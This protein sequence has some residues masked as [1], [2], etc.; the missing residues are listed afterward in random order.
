MGITAKITAEITADWQAAQ[1]ALAWQLDMGVD[2]AMGDAPQSA[3]DLP[4]KAEWQRPAAQLAA[5]APV[6][7]NLAASKP[8]SS[9]NLPPSAGLD[10]AQSAA[11]CKNLEELHAAI[12]QFDHL[13]L[14]KGARN[15]VFGAGNPRADILILGDAPSREDERD[16]IPFS[17][18]AGQ[19]LDRMFAAIGYS[20]HDPNPS[21][22]LY[23]TCALPW[24][25]PQD[26]S[27]NADEIDI[28]RPFVQRHID[29]VAPSVIVLMG[30]AALQMAQQATGIARARGTWGTAFGVDVMPMFP[31]AYVLANPAAKRDAWADLLAIKARLR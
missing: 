28:F 23:L 14:K 2:E 7:Q 13:E 11:A 6:V 25:T 1:A 20:Q 30:T 29:L 21:A 22:A 4:D 15:F 5:R 9:G 10:A 17:G 26:R 3:Y 8:V 27:P 12:Q 16:A 19:L 18:M 31:P 24:R